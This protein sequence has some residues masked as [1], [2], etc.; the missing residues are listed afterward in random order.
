ME[1][2]LISVEEKLAFQDDLLDALNKTVAKQQQQMDMLQ[3]EIRLLYQ[4]MKTLQPSSTEAS[5][6]PELPP[7]Y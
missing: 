1:N 6:E 4:Q 3:D 2:R 5:A 7:H